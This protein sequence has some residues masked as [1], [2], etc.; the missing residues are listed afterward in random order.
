MKNYEIPLYQD[1][2]LLSNFLDTWTIS[3]IEKMSLEEYTDV[4]NKDTF[5][6][7]VET[8]TIILGSIKGR[9][10]SSKFGVYKRKKPKPEKNL[11]RSSKFATSKPA[12]RSL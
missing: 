7:W 4:D 3:R 1:E 8:Q 11:T 5:T 9:I 12:A 10:G 2:E 6:Q